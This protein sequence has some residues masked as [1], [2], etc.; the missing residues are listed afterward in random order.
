MAASNALQPRRSGTAVWKQIEETLLSEILS[1]KIAPG[2]RLPSESA[3]ADQ[4]AVNRHTVRR[5]LAELGARDILQTEN[6][7][8]T[9]VTE[10]AL[11]YKMSKRVRSVE[12]MLRDG[13][14]MVV[15]VLDSSR[16]PATVEIAAALE[17]E[18]GSL[19]WIIDSLS[20][21]DGKPMIHARHCFPHQRFPDLP[22]R[23]KSARSIAATLATYGVKSTR[24]SMVI[25]ARLADRVEMKLLK[26]Q[27]PAP[28]LAVESLYVDQRG[29]PVDH[30][31]AH[32]AGSR[33][34][35]QI[36]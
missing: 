22:E 26:E 35:L 34:D 31:V 12:R 1:G 25:S 28:V 7:R 32:Y 21:I 30:G 36:D 4:F 8:G 6:G 17:V 13:H 27:W 19:L 3:L 14:D 24:K 29:K 10:K 33:I 23:Y 20:T 2:E 5:A 18:A 15:K 9:F 11:R 16:S